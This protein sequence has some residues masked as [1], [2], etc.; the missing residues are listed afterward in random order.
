[1]L[2]GNIASTPSSATTATALNDSYSQ[3]RLFTTQGEHALASVLTYFQERHSIESHYTQQLE[4]LHKKTLADSGVMYVSSYTK[5]ISEAWK[6]V[7]ECTALLAAEH[8]KLT[9]MLD[10][11]VDDLSKEQAAQPAEALKALRADVKATHR[12]YTDLKHQSVPKAKAA[13]YKKCEA[14]DKEPKEVLSGSGGSAMPG[15]TSQKYLKLAKEVAL[16]DQAYRSSI[17]Y[18]EEARERLNDARMKSMLDGERIEKRRIQVTKTALT[19]YCDSEN[20]LCQE[21]TKEM[22]SLRLFVE[23]IKEDI[24]VTLH[25]QEFHRAWPV[26]EHLFYENFK[27]KLPAK[28]LCDGHAGA[29]TRHSY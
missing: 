1:M 27:T 22:A 9:R 5:T 4:K 18:L 21:R 8:Q 24:D 7:G 3:Y 16:A 23:C 25:K 28:S 20:N 6:R 17:H 26:T 19:K 13:Y 2:Q 10:G 12:E 11:I 15:T 29:L 14:L